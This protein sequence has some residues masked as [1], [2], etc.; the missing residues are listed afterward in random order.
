MAGWMEWMGRRMH[1]GFMAN[2]FD[3]DVFCCSFR[4]KN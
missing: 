1:G 3:D 2:G 4:N